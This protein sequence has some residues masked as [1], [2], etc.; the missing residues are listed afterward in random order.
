MGVISR[1][2]ILRKKLF[3]HYAEFR[4]AVYDRSYHGEPISIHGIRYKLLVNDKRSRGI[5]AKRK[6]P[7]R[8]LIEWFEKVL[9][10]FNSFIDCGANFG[11]ITIPLA[12]KFRKPV[13]AIEPV[14]DNFSI[15]SENVQ[16]NHLGSIVHPIQAAVG[17]TCGQQI[18]YLGDKSGGHSF[19]PREKR[20]GEEVAVVTLDSCVAAHVELKPPFL[21]KIDTQGWEMEV[22]AGAEHLLQEPC[23]LS[24][25]FWPQGLKEVGSS[26]A[27][28]DAFCRSRSLQ[29][30]AVV[31]LDREVHQDTVAAI[32][33]TALSRVTSLEQL[34]KTLQENHQKFCDIVLT[35]MDAEESGIAPFIT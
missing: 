24:I 30:F 17:R 22:L 29:I 5:F 21:I 19:I 14:K 8:G 3:N 4:G 31:K 16:L 11:M 13:L 18:I 26:A 7:S 10:H 9:P 1:L 20:A 33:K 27:E 6:V 25:E 32:G 2:D 28:L 23:L 15:L 34:E 12:Y 35:N